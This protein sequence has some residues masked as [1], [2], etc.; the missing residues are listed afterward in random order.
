VA[1]VPAES[2]ASLAR[3]SDARRRKSRHISVSGRRIRVLYRR[4][5]T[6]RPGPHELR[7]SDADRELVIGLLSEAAADGRL[8][9][10]EHAERSERALAARTLGELTSLTADLA[11]PSGQPIRLYPRRSVTA[12]FARER[13]DGRWVVPEFLTVT[14]F[15]GNVVLDLRDAVLQKQRITIEAMSIA[16]QIRLIVPAGVAVE[17]VGRS[18]AGTRSVRA[19]TRA[20]TAPAAGNAVIEVRTLTLCGAV[21]VVTAR[22]SRWRSAAGRQGLRPGLRRN[23]RI[24]ASGQ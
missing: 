18:F 13:R 22:R 19:K 17:L 16:G 3:E 10:P 4:A 11:L 6:L 20:A 1:W 12:A 23:R 8:T 7:A 5:V 24:G 15:F 2:A 21:K 14:A 9:L